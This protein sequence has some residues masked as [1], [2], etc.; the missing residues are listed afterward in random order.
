MI[1]E[2]SE[3]GLVMHPAILGIA[4]GGQL[5][6][7]VSDQVPKLNVE[8]ACR[9]SVAADKAMGLDLPQ[10]FEKC[11]SDENSAQQQLGPIWSSYSAAIR[12]QCE[13]EAT[14]AGDAS[15]VDL[16]TCLQM[17]DGTNPN[18]STSLKG[19]SRRKSPK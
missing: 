12:A 6:M 3:K 7:L 2:H 19:A 17:T 15:Y 14:A 8:A 11:M 9:G 18:S 10:S 1:L 5:A 13:G 16:L 4:L